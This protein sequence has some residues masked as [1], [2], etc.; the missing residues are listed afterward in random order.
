MILLLLTFS[1]SPLHRLMLN[2]LIFYT[3]DKGWIQASS[4]PG[5]VFFMPRQRKMPKPFPGDQPCQHRGLRQHFR[6]PE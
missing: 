4:I 5:F 3:R 1:P 6:F 2:N